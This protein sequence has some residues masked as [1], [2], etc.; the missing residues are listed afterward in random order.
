MVALVSRQ[1]CL[2]LQSVPTRSLS[3]FGGLW[4]RVR[5]GLGVRVSITV[6]VDVRVRVNKLLQ[7]D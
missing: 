7:S 3:S 4:I 2:Y 5:F 1:R 6:R